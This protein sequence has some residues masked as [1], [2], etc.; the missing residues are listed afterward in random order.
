MFWFTNMFHVHG[1]LSVNTLP[2]HAAGI[3]IPI[4]ASFDWLA[5]SVVLLRPSARPQ[6]LAC[7]RRQ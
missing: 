6:Y 1:S 7:K 2:C 5:S 3:N 4:T